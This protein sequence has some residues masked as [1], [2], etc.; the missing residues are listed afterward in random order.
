MSRQTPMYRTVVTF[1]SLI[2]FLLVVAGCHDLN[3][4]VDP[5]AAAYQGFNTVADPSDVGPDTPP[6]GGT[7]SFQVFLASEILDGGTVPYHFTVLDENRSVCYDNDAVSG[8][9]LTSDL[10]LSE[11]TYSWTAAV[12][13]HTGRNDEATF[14]ARSITADAAY[15]GGST[16]DT[17]PLITWSPFSQA[18]GYQLQMNVDSD[19]FSAA[20]VETVEGGGSDTDPPEYQVPFDDIL[21][22]GNTVHWRV[23]P[24]TEH[25]GYGTLYGYWST[26]KSFEIA[27]DYT[28]ANIS[29]LNGE[30]INDTY[31]T[32]LWDPIEGA[33]AYQIRGD[34]SY[35][36]VESAVSNSTNNPS[37]TVGELEGGYYYW[38]VRPVNED[39]I[40]APEW[41]D[42]YSFEVQDIILYE[43]FENGYLPYDWYRTSYSDASWSV[44]SSD[45]Y[46]GSYSLKSNDIGSSEEAGIAVEV[47]CPSYAY[48]SFYKKVSSESGYDK[49]R[50][51][52]D[53]CEEDNWSGTLGGWTSHSYYLGSGYHTLKW[54]YDKD[55]SISSGSDCAWIDLVIVE[56]EY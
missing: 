4:P 9:A 13:G 23:R 6:D 21:Y 46:E 45:S 15:N 22:F 53:D 34:T 25:Q 17:T 29:P 11:G 48:V 14:T 2:G 18:Q 42:I 32:I 20:A 37:Y 19:D 49:L 10:G 55:G 39:G 35:D 38:Q 27:W 41:S 40:P 36:G 31:V 44:V 26:P 5:D 52:I 56:E 28:V 1:L 3:N 54:E 12:T 7:S 33:S 50:F 16:Y 51:Y 43:D 24:V 30:L 47:Y 8:N